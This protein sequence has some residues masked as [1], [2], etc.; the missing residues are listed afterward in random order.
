MCG[1]GV[2]SFYELIERKG[3]SPWGAELAI[4]YDFLNLHATLHHNKAY[5]ILGSFQTLPS[6]TLYVSHTIT[7]RIAAYSGL[8]TG[9]L[10]LKNVRAYDS[11]GRIYSIE[12]NTWSLTPS[13]GATYK[14]GPVAGARAENGPGVA[15]FLEASYEVRDFASLAYTLPSDIKALPSD[16]PRR[17][18]ASGPVLNVGF[19]VTFP[20]SKPD[21]ACCRI[22]G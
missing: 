10:W 2:E 9:L 6:F 12:A 17:F 11:S 20:R 14:L 15:F 8:G 1:W 22:V 16:L 7:K 13:I 4:G 18:F 3:S 19:E 21:K 5:E